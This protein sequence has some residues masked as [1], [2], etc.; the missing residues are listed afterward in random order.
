M[1][2]SDTYAPIVLSN[3]ATRIDRVGA[4]IDEPAQHRLVVGDEATTVEHVLGDQH[5]ERQVRGYK[6]GG[7]DQCSAGRGDLGTETRRPSS[8]QPFAAAYIVSSSRRTSGP[9]GW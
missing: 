4:V 1:I 5:E 9:H 7:D 3:L 2:A 6:R 8:D